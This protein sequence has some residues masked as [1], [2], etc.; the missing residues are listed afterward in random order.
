MQNIMA[1]LCI[2][3]L[4]LSGCA[5]A[6]PADPL[7]GTRWTLE[8]LNGEAPLASPQIWLAF[9]NGRVRGH[10]GCN[11][12]DGPYQVDGATLRLHQLL[13]SAMICA[14]ETMMRQE[15]EFSNALRLTTTFVLREG[16]RLE[17]QD[18]TGET[19]LVF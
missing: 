7:S 5:T 16:R 2:G 9:T 17:L 15:Q 4:A 18:A 1:A 6:P 11:E 14:D 12:L 19:R 10:M 8:R 3:V 13:E